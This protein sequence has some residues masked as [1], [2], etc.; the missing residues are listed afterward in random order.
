MLKTKRHFG[1]RGDYW[2]RSGITKNTPITDQ[3]KNSKASMIEKYKTQWKSK[4]VG[5]IGGSS[6]KSGVVLD[7]KLTVDGY[8]LRTVLSVKW[9]EA[10][11]KP[12]ISDVKINSIYDLHGYADYLSEQSIAIKKQAKLVDNYYDAL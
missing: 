2:Y 7:A 4:T 8:Y 6:Q 11:K 5:M 9:F 12:K 10:G 1:T 3:E